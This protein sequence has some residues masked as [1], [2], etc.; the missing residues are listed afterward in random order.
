MIDPDDIQIQT[1]NTNTEIAL[2]D[3]PE[4]DFLVWDLDDDRDLKKYWKAVE[5][6]V[7]KSY[8]Y[9]EFI[10]YI[11]ENYSMNQCSFL[12]VSNKE[13]FDIKIE[14]HH[15]PFTLFDIVQIVYRKRIYYQESLSVEM[16]SKEVTMLHYRL[17]VGLIPLSETVHQLVHD[18]KLFIPVSNILGRYKLFIDQYKPFCESEQLEVIDRIEQYTDQQ[19]TLFNSSILDTNMIRFAPKDDEYKLPD[20]NNIQ[21]N[22][23]NRITEIKNNDYRLPKYDD[24]KEINKKDDTKDRRSII[25]PIYFENEKRQS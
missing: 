20:F 18:G 12:Q 1:R 2:S 5:S 25:K 23:S 17:M 14:I 7:R 3:V 16:T 6:E 21:N 24:Y 13:T 11:R 8:E 15:Y 22:M 9:R 10:A 19:N 4:Y